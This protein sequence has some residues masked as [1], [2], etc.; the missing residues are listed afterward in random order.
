M[1]HAIN[2]FIQP[3]VSVDLTINKYEI[4]ARPVDY[5]NRP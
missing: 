5:E 2:H 3:I 4:L 1:S